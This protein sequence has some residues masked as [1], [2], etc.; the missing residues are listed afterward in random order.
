MT[1]LSGA[2]YNVATLTRCVAVSLSPVWRH[3]HGRNH[4]LQ[5]GA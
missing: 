4:S 5:H 3:R 2:E 1:S